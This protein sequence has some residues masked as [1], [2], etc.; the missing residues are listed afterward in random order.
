MSRSF[1]NVLYNIT[2]S[3]FPNKTEFNIGSLQLGGL[4]SVSHFTYTFYTTEN[5][6]I[7]VSKKYKF[8]DKGYTKFMII[9]NN[10]EHYDVANNLWYWKWDSVEDWTNIKEDHNI[11]VRKY[12]VRVPV[13]GLFPVIVK[14]YEE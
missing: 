1:I 12:G 10:G 4:L 5:V 9:D 11:I 8:D 7:T 3:L 13:L 14:I 2:R 6:E